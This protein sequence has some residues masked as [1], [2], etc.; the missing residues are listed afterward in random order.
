MT[1]I[2]FIRTYFS[3]SLITKLVENRVPVSSVI[4]DTIFTNRVSRATSRISLAQIQRVTKS[5][6]VISRGGQAM[7]LVMRMARHWYQL[8]LT[9]SS[10]IS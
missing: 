1:L 5:M 6:P 4:F 3:I 7:A 9:G 10:W 8:S 2:E